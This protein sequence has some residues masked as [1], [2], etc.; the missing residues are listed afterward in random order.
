MFL[1][2]IV[3]N[4]LLVKRKKI[5]IFKSALHEMFQKVL[6]RQKQ[7]LESILLGDTK[8]LRLYFMIYFI[9]RLSKTMYFIGS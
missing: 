2:S 9:G 4:L 3:F 7:Q 1:F 6:Q 5:I 8:T